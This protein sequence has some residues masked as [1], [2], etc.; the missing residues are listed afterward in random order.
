MRTARPKKPSVDELLPLR[1][2]GDFCSW[3]VEVPGL[4]LQPCGSLVGGKVLEYALQLQLEESSL[5]FQVISS[6]LGFKVRLYPKGDGLV[7]AEENMGA[8]EANAAVGG[9][10]DGH[11][12]NFLIQLSQAGDRVCLLVRLALGSK[13]VQGA[14]I[15]AQVT[16]AKPGARTVIACVAIGDGKLTV[17]HGSGSDPHRQVAWSSDPQSQRL[18]QLLPLRLVGQPCNWRLEQA[19]LLFSCIES[20]SLAEGSGWQG[21]CLCLR[22]LTRQVDFQIVS[23]KLGFGW[24]LFPESTVAGRIKEC[25]KSPDNCT[26]AVVGGKDD[27]GGLNFMITGRPLNVITI[28]VWLNV[29]EDKVTA[30]RIGYAVPSR[31]DK[32]EEAVPRVAVGA[33]C[34]AAKQESRTSIIHRWPYDPTMGC[35]GSLDQKFL[36]SC[37]LFDFPES[38]SEGFF[39]KKTLALPHYHTLTLPSPHY[40]HHTTITTLQSPLPSPHSNHHTPHYHHITSSIKFSLIS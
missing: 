9:C 4:E 7:K 22:L 32:E 38:F 36:V 25:S 20:S 23:G 17:I 10:H 24:R 40:N 14:P 30:A 11:G 29:Q 19:G 21:H 26:Q 6:L 33:R 15:A 16:Y 35:R 2:V 13:G 31:N 1:L 39:E 18:P 28:Y 37:F 3:Q 12:R 34:L 27:G 8:S 5:E